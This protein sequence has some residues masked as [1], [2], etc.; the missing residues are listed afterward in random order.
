MTVRPS[1]V[2]RHPPAPSSNSFPFS[3]FRCSCCVFS[4]TLDRHR[5]ATWTLLQCR[6]RS[7]NDRIDCSILLFL[8]S[9]GLVHREMQHYL[10]WHTSLYVQLWYQVPYFGYYH[11]SAFFVISV[12]WRQLKTNVLPAVCTGRC[13]DRRKD[14]Q[15]FHHDSNSCASF[16]DGTTHSYYLLLR[17]IRTV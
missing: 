10:L 2:R 1:A 5:N 16:F 15:L 11:L 8:K 13:C 6:A 17:P 7:K 3:H 14:F 4:W 12:V 9:V